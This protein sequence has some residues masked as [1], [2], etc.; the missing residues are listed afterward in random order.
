[1]GFVAGV[2][3]GGTFTDLIMVDGETGDVRVAKVPSTPTNQAEGVMAALRAAGADL[4]ALQAIVHGTTVATNAILERRGSRCGLITT[5]G[6]RDTLEIGRRTRPFSYGLIGHYEPLIPRNL[7]IEVRE[8]IGAAGQVLTPLD[9]DGVCR[10]VQR[11]REAGAESVVVCFLHSYANPAHEARALA[12]VRETWPNRFV[13][14]SIEVLPEFREFERVS[15][16]AVNGYVQPLMHRYLTALA[17]RLEEAGCAGQLLV[18]QANGGTMAAHVA[19]ERAVNTVVSGPAAGVIAAAHI[20]RLAGF[21]H[22]V[23][24]DM[25]GT[26]FDVGVI[27]GGKPTIS[28]EKE[29]DYSLPVRVSMIDLTTI[30]AGGGSIATVDAGGILQVGPASAGA[31]PGPIC[32]GLGGTAPTIT[33]AN[34][35]LGRLSRDR[36]LAVR[37]AASLAEVERGL[38]DK[39]GAPLG[40][41]ATA[42]AEAIVRVGND[43][44]AGAI[45]MVTLERGHDPRDFAL[46]AFGGAGPLHA[47]A[48]ARELH[49]P[50]VIVPLMPGITSALGCL[51]ADMRH[52]F[53]RTVN[54]RVDALE[55]AVLVALFAEQAAQGR[56]ILADERVPITAVDTLHEVD[57]QFDGQT[58]VIRLEV[59]PNVTDAAGLAR[60]FRAAYRDRFGV[61]LDEMTP[62]VINAR[63]SVLGRRTPIDL[64]RIAASRA[65]GAATGGAAERR[66]V[67]HAGALHD[68]PVHSRDALAVGTK[69]EGPAIVEQ[70]DA[71][72]WI[73][74]GC[75]AVVDEY[76]NLIISLTGAAPSR[77]PHIRR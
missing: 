48:L 37:Q 57:M 16:M 63:T 45:R 35:H 30:G 53:V 70:L 52:D 15:T 12:I 59:G 13:S 11:L 6:F 21:E 43:K 24:C 42:A 34:L 20:A 61:E 9:E 66:P 75:V 71:T 31:V 76:R 72:T 10:A 33:D 14:G 65:S 55:F 40:L 38:V 74:P 44:M 77:E 28:A 27:L 2:D 64:R 67:W 7:R 58:H 47:V 69:L 19:A 5:H 62:K 49:I 18:I 1:M 23:T 3:V 56:A 60:L 36:L 26:S 51:L 50:T 4:H 54:Q 25:G 39:V 8:R 22:V 32:Y 68:T 29:I 41:D 73:E 17:S 46:L